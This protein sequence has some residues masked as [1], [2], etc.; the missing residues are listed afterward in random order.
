MKGSISKTFR[1][2]EDIVKMFNELKVFLG[3]YEHSDNVTM[4]MIIKR[5]YEDVYIKQNE[6]KFAYMLDLLKKIYKDVYALDEESMDRLNLMFNTILD[7][8]KMIRIVCRCSLQ[9][10]LSDYVSFID[11]TMIA[12]GEDELV[13]V[14][15]NIDMWKEIATKISLRLVKELHISKTAHDCLMNLICQLMYLIKNVE[16]VGEEF[17]AEELMICFSEDKAR[18]NIFEEV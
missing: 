4:N 11:G 14:L 16:I 12:F 17:V 7:E 8:L 6:E 15:V 10:V 2:Q 1:F 3:A 9:K 5:Y 18:Y 13:E